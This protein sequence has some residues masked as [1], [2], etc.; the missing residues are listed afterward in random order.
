MEHLGNLEQLTTTF[1]QSRRRRFFSTLLFVHLM[2]FDGIS[3]QTRHDIHESLQATAAARR[4]AIAANPTRPRV[5]FGIQ[6]NLLVLLT[7]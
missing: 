1:G 7:T 5:P 3:F 4:L 2:M 6:R